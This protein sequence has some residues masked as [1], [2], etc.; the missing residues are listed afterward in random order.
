M[1][2]QAQHL[3]GWGRTRG[4]AFL[5]GGCV[6]VGRSGCAKGPKCKGPA[7]AELGG[8]CKEQL[9][10]PVASA[11]APEPI[12]AGGNLLLGRGTVGKNLEA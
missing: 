2:D 12:A 8:E 4:T 3:H 1:R 11:I 5:K 7:A 9:V 10:A 6:T